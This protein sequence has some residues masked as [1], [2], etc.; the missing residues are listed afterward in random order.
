MSVSATGSL[1]DEKFKIQNFNEQIL[2]CRSLIVAA[3]NVSSAMEKFVQWVFTGVLA[4]LAY[5]LAHQKVSFGELQPA[6]FTFIWAGTIGVIQRYLAMMVAIGSQVFQEAE[7]LDVEKR[8][9]DLARFL[10]VY[11][12][13]QPR[14]S[15]WAAAGAARRLMR[16]K[17]C[18]DWAH[19][20]ENL[21]LAI[22]PGPWSDRA[23]ST[24]IIFGAPCCQQYCEFIRRL[25][26]FSA[27]RLWLQSSLGRMPR[28]VSNA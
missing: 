12:D 23:F 18:R 17:C 28:F 7:K 25:A 3:K 21:D 14:F 22:F 5:F 16:R 27:S 8:P 20:T 2:A 24:R 13:A 26:A 11:I 1:R 9:I 4:G 10:I 6:L 19:V 15:R